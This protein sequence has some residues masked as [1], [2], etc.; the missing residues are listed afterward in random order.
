MKRIFLALSAAVVL[1]SPAVMAQAKLVEKVTA[2][3]SGK[4]LV[5]PYEKYVLPNGLTLIVHEDH[6]DPLVH[7]DVTYHVGSARE[8]IGK[9]GFA[10]FF[11]H[12]MF[13]GSDNVADEQHFSIITEA[14]GEL[15]GTTNRDRTNYF[16]TVPSNQLEKM[17]WLEAD[18]MGFLLD[19]VTQ[20]K[21]EVQRATVKNERGQRYDNVPYGLVSEVTAKNL[22]PYGHPYSWLTIGYVEDLNRVNVNDLKNFFMRWYGPN[23]AAVTVG[24]DVNTKEVVQLVEKYFGSIPKGPEVTDM[25]PQTFTLPS[26]R[27]VS[28]VDN[29][30][31]LP[32]LRVTY[33]GVPAHHKDE[34]P[35]DAL[36][37]IL[38][39]FNNKNSIIYQQLVKT[40]QAVNAFAMHPTSELAGEFV[41]SI[42]PFPGK[43]LSDMDQA[44]R[45]ALATFEKRGVTDEDIEKFR[46]A[47]E[48][49]MIMGLGSVSGKVSQLAAY[50]T[51][52]G[53]PNYLAADLDRYMKVT[54][55]DV[56]RV[57]NQYVKGKHAVVVSVLTKDQPENRA[58]AD[59]YTV[60]TAGYKAPDYG[61][62]GLK[63]VKAKDNFDRTKMPGNGANPVV[64]V[65]EFWRKE[66][67]GG[68]RTIGTK[69]DEIPV[70]NVMLKFKGGKMMDANDPSKA[71][72]SNLF[73]AMMQEDT[74]NYTA[75]QL[76]TELEKL[77]SQIDVRSTT[78]GIEVAVVSLAKNFDKTMA[79]V[80]ERLL[81]PKFTEE[82]FATN[83][84]RLLEMIKNNMNRPGYLATINYQKLLFGSDNVLAWPTMGTE[85]TVK[86]IQLQDV[87]NYYNNYISKSDA[88]AVVVGNIGQDQ[89]LKGINFLQQLPAKEVKLPTLAAAPAIEKTKIYFIDVPNAAQTE[90]RI[91]YVTGMKYDATGD[92]FKSTVM[93]YPFGGAFNSRLNLDLREERG[94]TYGARAGFDGNKY[95]GSYT[96]GSGIKAN[97][98]DS[99]MVDILKIMREYRDKGITPQELSF[100]QNSMGQADARKY[101]EGE[102]KAAFLSRILEY[103]LPSNFPTKQNEILRNLTTTDVQRLI[104]RYIPNT[105]KMNVLLVGDKARVWDGLQKLGYEIV[106]LDRNGNPIAK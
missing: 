58:A 93:N 79:L 36:A 77:G 26:T 37:D 42:T 59:N 50:Q 84:N 57:Y 12:M 55:E 66:L 41:F 49:E 25:T 92:Y 90:F 67:P 5:I 13:Q 95:T 11:E 97:A 78:D 2:D 17:L 80:Q 82:A 104:T 85:A 69:T 71:G 60:S 45:E 83:K 94:W 51:F 8:E 106:E 24:G 43:K 100:T 88:Q 64:K 73:A 62:D 89:A 3:K 18:R 81:N 16:E 96:F 48:A 20:K 70:V 28:F 30:A 38:G 4:T 39:G 15:N 65:P 40:Q 27:Y 54:K 99:A 102:Q 86:N 21:F 23:N 47:R 72:L 29:Y 6:S 32:Q 52:E 53:N 14:G 63:Y 44:V 31:K 35:L 22:Y 61:Y 101:E 34:A 19:A 105:E 9:S 74:K 98:T 56:L 7:V 87:Q 46:N 76:G 10:H 75:E 1:Y 68:I 103:N 33:P 91:G